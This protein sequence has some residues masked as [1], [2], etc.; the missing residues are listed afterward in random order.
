MSHA[1]EPDQVNNGVLAVILALV[2]LAVLG[3]ALFVTSIVRDE[4]G[5]ATA[6]RSADQDRETR[7]LKNQQLTGLGKG[8]E[9]SDRGKGLVQ[10]SIDQAMAL[11]LAA[12]RENP[13]ALS[14]GVKP[15]ADQGMGGA[16]G[17]EVSEAGEKGP[18]KLD[19]EKA[20]DNK[21][22]LEKKP[23][24][25]EKKVAPAPVAPT[26]GAPAPAPGAPTTP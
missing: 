7:D 22:A 18:S 11:T 5:V 3:I 17:D 4:V 1:N 21:A 9:Y 20:T 10:V 19:N 8:P 16:S 6:K 2:T 25:A 13:Y 12:V 14:P 26:P 15:A 24:P 23:A